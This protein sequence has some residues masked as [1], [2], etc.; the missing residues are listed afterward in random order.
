[1]GVRHGEEAKPYEG[2]LW[3][4]LPLPPPRPFLPLN[5]VNSFWFFINNP[6][7]SGMRVLNNAEPE[8]VNENMR[9]ISAIMSTDWISLTGC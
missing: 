1:M 5:N 8:V 9:T 7:G 6:G 2:P 3:T 4:I